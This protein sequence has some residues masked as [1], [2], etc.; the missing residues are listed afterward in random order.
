MKSTSDDLGKAEVTGV[1]NAPV[2]LGIMGLCI[3]IEAVMQLGDAGFLSFPRFRSLVYEYGGFWP[4][5]LN[6]W[7]PNYPFQSSAM[8]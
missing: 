3:G 4:G 8:F 1:T 5:L 2:V 7:G 6:T